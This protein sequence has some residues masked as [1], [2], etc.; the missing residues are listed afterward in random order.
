MRRSNG[1][2]QSLSCKLGFFTSMHIFANITVSN[3]YPS[4]SISFQFYAK[5]SHREEELLAIDVERISVQELV[6]RAQTDTSGTLLL[7][8]S[9]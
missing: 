3:T 8:A 7:G 2:A 4:D 1:P 9:T 6:Q 5:H